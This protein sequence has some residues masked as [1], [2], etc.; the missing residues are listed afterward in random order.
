MN[1][2]QIEH[3]L[4]HHPSTTSYFKGVFSP[5]LAPP[6]SSENKHCYVFNVD[7]SDKPGSHWVAFY[8]DDGRGEFFDSY[9]NAPSFY[10]VELER[11]LKKNCREWKTN[12]IRLQGTYST[13]CGQYCIY[14]LIKRCEGKALKHIVNVFGHDLSRNDTRVNTWFNKKYNASL[15][16]HDVTFTRMQIAQSVEKNA[17]IF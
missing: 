1:T 15:P 7:S 2:F 9:A 13:V 5:D 4:N 16:T 10:N 6:V 3:V 14:Y 17:G 11:F 8:F 12:T